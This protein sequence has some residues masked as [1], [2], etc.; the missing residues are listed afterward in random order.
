MAPRT[1]NSIAHLKQ[2]I[3]RETTTTTTTAYADD[4]D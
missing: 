2:M 3:D 4:G 1:P